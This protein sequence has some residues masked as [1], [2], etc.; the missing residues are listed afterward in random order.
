MA[1]S[2]DF[3]NFE[4]AGWTDNSVAISYHRQL[5]EV[6]RGCIAELVRAAHVKTGDKVLDVACGAGYVAA[7]ARDNGADATGVDFSAIQIQLARQIYPGI[8]F[9]EGDAEALPFTDGAF[10]AVLN[11][12]GMPHVPNPDRAAAEAHRVL[13]S[14]GRFAY[15]SWCEATKCVAFSMIYDAIRAHGSLD[16]GLPPGPNFFG[17]GEPGYATDLLVRAGFTDVSAVEVPWF[18]AF[19]LPMRSSKRFPP[20]PYA[21]Q[22]SSIVRARRASQASRTICATRLRASNKMLLMSFHRLR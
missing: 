22:R 10:D 12:F 1:G 15:A 18:G 8:E 7:A 13:K 2:N 4:Q 21:P 19:L 9:I 11:S 3:R 14:S 20:P 16:V 6:T 5:S 17:Y